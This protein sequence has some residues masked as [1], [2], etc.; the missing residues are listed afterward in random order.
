MDAVW[1]G[2]VVPWRIMP[3]MLRATWRPTTADGIPV[4]G[5]PGAITG[6]L[7]LVRGVEMACGGANAIPIPIPIPIPNTLAFRGAW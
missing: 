5:G 6:P 2:W 3:A 1:A 7:G 4:R